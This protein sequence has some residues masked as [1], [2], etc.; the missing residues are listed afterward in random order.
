M[1]DSQQD[2][3]ELSPEEIKKRAQQFRQKYGTGGQDEAGV[4]E[5]GP[6][7]ANTKD[8]AV[9][10]ALLPVGGP[11]LRAGAKALGFLGEEAAEKGAASAGRSLLSTLAEK[12]APEAAEV[13]P[14]FSEAVEAGT[15]KPG[16]K[17]FS[18]F[19]RGESDAAEAAAP[20]LSKEAVKDSRFGTGSDRVKQ[21]QDEWQNLDRTTD[22]G[23]QRAKEIDY[24]LKN[25]TYFGK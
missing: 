1:P 23:R 8:L 19:I 9:Q 4:E 13:S 24:A 14:T 16:G 3:T 7:E 5:L 12:G 18:K 10:A 2:D 6:N 25:R 20:D 17:S 22:A 15:A 21:L 11:E